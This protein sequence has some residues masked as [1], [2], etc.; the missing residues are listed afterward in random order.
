MLGFG[1]NDAAILAA[2]SRPQVMAN[3][4]SP[5]VAQMRFTAALD[6]ELGRSRGKNPYEHYLC[7]NSGS[8]SVSLACRIADVNA[9]AMTDAGAR[10]AGRPI[11]RLAVTG[12]FHG[13]TEAPALYSDSSRKPHQQNLASYPHQARVTTVAPDE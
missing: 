12:A 6:K 10:Y 11:K 9:K 5:S 13:R 8:E 7:L 1:H 4:M 2:L 3:V